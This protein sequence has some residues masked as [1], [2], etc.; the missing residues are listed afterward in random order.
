MVSQ[1]I[2]WIGQFN[3]LGLDPD[4]AATFGFCLFLF[5][6]SEFFRLFELV[7]SHLTKR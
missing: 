3:N 6:V 7:L 5:A 1:L 2:N 4:L